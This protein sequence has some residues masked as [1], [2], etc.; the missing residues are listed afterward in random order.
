MDNEPILVIDEYKIYYNN[1]SY[2]GLLAI[3]L[4]NRPNQGYANYWDRIGDI[5]IIRERDN[6]DGYYSNVNGINIYNILNRNNFE[7]LSDI[8]LEI[9]NLINVANKLCNSGFLSKLR[10]FQ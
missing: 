6:V 10:I 5:G 1:E 9:Q 4:P 2:G 8:R 7:K 3:Y